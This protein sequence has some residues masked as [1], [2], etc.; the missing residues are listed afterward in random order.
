MKKIMMLAALAATFASPVGARTTA[1][2]HAEYAA[3]QT[4]GRYAYLKAMTTDEWRAL[5]DEALAI[6]ATNVAAAYRPEPWTS[7]YLFSCSLPAANVLAG[8]YDPKFAAAGIGIKPCMY[9]YAPLSAEAWLTSDIPSRVAWKDAHPLAVALCRAH[10]NG[11]EHSWTLPERLNFRAEYAAPVDCTHAK[12]VPWSLDLGKIKASMLAKA[13]G[14]VKRILRTR[15]KS[16]V[17]QPDGS[18]PVQEALDTL[19]TA[20]NAPR[21]AGLKEWVAEWYP[22]YKWVEPHWA[23]AEDLAKVTDD[24]YYGRVEFSD[25]LKMVLCANMGVE[26]Y[27][28]FV[29][30]YN[31]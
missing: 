26:E 12:H 11:Y 16:F 20:L 31:K 4:S 30:R 23:T 14:E 27:N 24:V 2:I 1:E 19:S 15:G 18:N 25:Y 3:L 7:V 22:E 9:M 5:A 28:K 17:V 13:P 10:K 6:A 8:E 29:E 21:M